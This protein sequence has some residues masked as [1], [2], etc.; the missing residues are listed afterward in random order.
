MQLQFY[1]YLTSNTDAIHYYLEEVTASMYAVTRL[2]KTK[3]FFTGTEVGVFKD[4]E[5]RE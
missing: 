3:S 2:Y 5:S 1:M 4:T